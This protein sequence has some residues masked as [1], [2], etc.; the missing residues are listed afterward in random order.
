[1]LEFRPIRQ[2]RPPGKSSEPGS[3]VTPSTRQ[4]FLPYWPGP[5]WRSRFY[6]CYDEFN[7]EVSLLLGDFDGCLITLLKLRASKSEFGACL[8]FAGPAASSINNITR[9][10][11]PVQ[12][13]RST[14]S[15]APSRYSRPSIAMDTSYLTTQVTTIIGQLHGIFDEIGV[16]SQERESRETEVYIAN[17]LWILPRLTRRSSSRLYQRLYTIN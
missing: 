3:N 6:I 10:N 12:I 17:P 11:S 13:T 16:Q 2:K 14:F 8:R 7:H 9:S 15:T 4:T 5:H 1:V